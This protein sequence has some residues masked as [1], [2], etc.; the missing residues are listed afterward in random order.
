MSAFLSGKAEAYVHNGDA[1]LLASLGLRTT[2]F[3][4]GE[5]TDLGTVEIYPAETSNPY[6]CLT[7]PRP[8]TTVRCEVTALPAQ[9]FRFTITRPRDETIDDESARLGW[10]SV[11]EPCD[12][13][14]INTG[15]GGFTDFWPSVK[16]IAEHMI[17]VKRLDSYAVGA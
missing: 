4:L 3:T 5:R 17:S 11:Y 14:E 1:K 15:T 13:Y 2:G 10:R 12:L 16:L 8:A 7:G 6:D 9:F